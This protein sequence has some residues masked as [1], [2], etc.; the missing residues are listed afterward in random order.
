MCSVF[1]KCIPII[2]Y[3][4]FYNVLIYYTHKKSYTKIDTNMQS[5]IEKKIKPK[6]EYLQAKNGVR[7]IKEGYYAFFTDPA[8]SYWLINDI[9]TER[10]KCD[11]GELSINRPEATAYLVPKNSP[12]KKL[13]SYA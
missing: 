12:Y 3:H 1:E 6:S 10:E 2:I 13:I 8:I 7:K 5:I 9:F 11:L 4:N